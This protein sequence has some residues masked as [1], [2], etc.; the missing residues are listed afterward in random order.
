[1]NER[2]NYKSE[3]KLINCAITLRKLSLIIVK[4]DLD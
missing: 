3:L 2:E 4:V 1:M